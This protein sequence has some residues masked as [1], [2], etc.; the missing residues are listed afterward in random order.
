MTHPCCDAKST[1]FAQLESENTASMVLWFRMAGYM[2]NPFSQVCRRWEIAWYIWLRSRYLVF[3]PR[4]LKET[5]ALTSG[6]VW[7]ETHWSDPATDLISGRSLAPKASEERA[8]GVLLAQAFYEG[9]LRGLQEVDI[10]LSIE[11]EVDLVPF[12]GDG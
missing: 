7:P 3:V 12:E 9:L 2:L 6:R 10:L 8:F 5:E 4:E 11:S 1:L